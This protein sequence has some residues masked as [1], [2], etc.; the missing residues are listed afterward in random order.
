MNNMRQDLINMFTLKQ[1][2]VEKI[3]LETVKLTEKP[4]DG[5]KNFT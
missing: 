1:E 5:K 4:T 2:A 3:A